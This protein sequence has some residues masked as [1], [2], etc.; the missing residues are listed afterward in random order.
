M[1]SFIQYRY[2]CMKQLIILMCALCLTACISRLSS[3]EISGHVINEKGEPLS[4]VEVGES[5][6]GANG[7]FKLP[8][9]RYYAFF[10]TELLLMEAPAVYVQKYV[11]KAGFQTCMLTYDNPYGGGQRAGAQWHVGKI[12]LQQAQAEDLAHEITD[13]RLKTEEK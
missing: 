4:H 12:V 6:T 7:E 5:V 2:F 8:E 3:P 10:L 1:A 9:K 11:A 13:C